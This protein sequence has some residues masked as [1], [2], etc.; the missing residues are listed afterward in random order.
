MNKVDGNALNGKE[1]SF[2]DEY[3]IKKVCSEDKIEL[4]IKKNDDY[5]NI[6]Q[7][8]VIGNVSAVV[9]CNGAGKTTLLNYIMDS[10]WI[11]FKKQEYRQG[12]EEYTKERYENGKTVQIFKDNNQ[13]IIV[14]NLDRELICKYAASKV[15][16]ITAESYRGGAVLDYQKVTRVY[17]TNSSYINKDG[18]SL[19]SGLPDTIWLI[20]AT[21][22][23]LSKTY[24]K[25]IVG[26]NNRNT[27]YNKIQ[28][29]I[30][31]HRNEMTFQSICDIL[32]FHYLESKNLL[33]NFAGKVSNELNITVNSFINILEY[34]YEDKKEENLDEN[35]EKYWSNIKRKIEN[36]K[37][38]SNRE[39]YS[40]IDSL[41]LNLLF[42]LNAI[43][44]FNLTKYQDLKLDIL[45][46]DI[47]NLTDEIIKEYYKNAIEEINEFENILSG[48]EYVKNAL[49]KNDMAYKIYLNVSMEKDHI[50]Y[51]SF[52][53]F[54]HKK[55]KE[56]NSFILKYLNVDNL[57]M[58]S[59]EHAYL[60]IFSWLNLLNFFNII[61]P[62]I[63]KSTQD[64]IL[65]LIDEI[66]LYLHPEWQRK[67]VSFL[68][69]ELQNQFKGKRIQVIF[70]TH[71]PIILSDIPKSN[72]VYLKKSNN[73]TI[74]DE[75]NV[76]KESFAANIFNLF[77][78]SFFLDAKG[79]VGE[80]AIN[81]VNKVYKELS[82][83]IHGR[84][85]ENIDIER[86]KKIDFIIDNIGEP[87]IKHKLE[88]M[89]LKAFPEYNDSVIENQ[90]KLIEE[91][92]K[93]ISNK[94]DCKN[95]KNLYEQLSTITTDIGRLIH[96]TGD[97]HD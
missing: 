85:N 42:E 89:K 21:L 70:A 26:L 84:N 38:F 96:K 33:I 31:N 46:N 60:N 40:L 28:Q 55:A 13:L 35:E 12:Y 45:C 4:E 5:Y 75:R 36:Y 82:D 67:M 81:Q 16:S 87:L 15:I 30:I 25:N 97:S 83:I 54:I 68:L 72:I 61:D 86:H 57:K 93:N 18:Y 52:L 1:I 53:S 2:T 63:Q 51:G 32:Y 80:F 44:G 56:Q 90:K 69:S 71:S 23:T 64:N 20:P 22:K 62:T 59:G 79:A 50:N 95:L 34:K 19:K 24:Y 39:E 8:Q 7:N 74:I 76:H 10:N 37:L 48:F 77:N 43:F 17:L 88:K 66:D 58:S 78:D 91:L 41:K 3:T 94:S 29:I 11:R 14:H 73:Q 27:Q 6:F 49:P 92:R 47:K 9:G 65:L